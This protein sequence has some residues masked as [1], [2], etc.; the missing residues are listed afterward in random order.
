MVNF[1]T[2][3]FDLGSVY[4]KGPTGSPELY[5]PAKPGYLLVNPHDELFDLPRDGV[6]AA[7]LGDPRNDENLIVAQLHVVF[8]RMH[9]KLRDAG[10]TF[11]QAQQQ[12]RWTYQYLIVNDFLPRIVGQD[13]VTSLIRRRGTGPIQF[14]GRLYQPRNVNKPYMPV[15]Y[16]GAAYR[17]GHSMIRAEYEVQ[18]GHTVPIFGQD[19]YE[20]LRGN[21]PIPPTLWIDWNYFFEIPGMNTPDD[22]N[23][24]RLIDTQL[25][26]P[27]SKLPSTVVAPTAGAIVA[28]AE[29]NLLRGKRLGL[30]AGQD[31]AAAMG[32]TPLTNAQLGLTE[33]GWK[34]KAPLWFYILKESELLGA[35]KLGPVGGRIVAEVILGPD[36]AGQDLVLHRQPLVRAGPEL[37]DGRLR[38][39]GRR[40]RPAGAGPDARGA[41]G[42]Q[43]ARGAGCAGSPRAARRGGA[44]GAGRRGARGRHR[45]GEAPGGRADQP[46]GDRARRLLVADR[47]GLTPRGGAG[48]AAGG[49]ALSGGSPSLPSCRRDPQEDR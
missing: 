24:A 2:P 9:N 13:V 45:R 16:S 41:G 46:R 1:D 29:R 21:R 11:E 23:M 44:R 15:E 19:G 12:L 31:V 40:D 17:F 35:K 7:Y 22:R 5:D 43:R 18:D 8:L 25:S 10:K 49:G 4:G 47:P 34:G 27:L 42:P 28:L 32:I 38:P 48:R 33:P 14:T 37:Q 20:D 6:G 26:L 3:R 39:R 36:G 30:P